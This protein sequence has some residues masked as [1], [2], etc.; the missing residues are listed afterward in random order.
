MAFPFTNSRGCERCTEGIKPI[1]A[2]SFRDLKG[3]KAVKLLFAVLF[4]MSL[5][6]VYI[7]HHLSAAGKADTTRGIPARNHTDA[8]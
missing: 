1:T 3:K 7:T 2:M 4:L 8:N 6:L 5:K